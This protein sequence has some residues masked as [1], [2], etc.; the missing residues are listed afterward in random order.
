[1]GRFVIKK[2]SVIPAQAGIHHLYSNFKQAC[3]IML[4]TV[5]DSRLRGNDEL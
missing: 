2:S 1:M 5:M 3:F 4:G